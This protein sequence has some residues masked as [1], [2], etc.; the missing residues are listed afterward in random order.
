MIMRYVNYYGQIKKE[1]IMAELYQVEIK[2]NGVVKWVDVGLTK[3]Q[4]K[5][6]DIEIKKKLE[7]KYKWDKLEVIQYIYIGSEKF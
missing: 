5:N 6:A 2:L 3:T 1:L 7:S 4:S